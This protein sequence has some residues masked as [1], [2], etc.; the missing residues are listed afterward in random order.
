M[1]GAVSAVVATIRSSIMTIVLTVLGGILAS[2][3]RARSIRSYLRGLLL[4]LFLPR[5]CC[6]RRCA[7]RWFL[8][9]RCCCRC[10]CVVRRQWWGFVSGQRWRIGLLW[11]RGCCLLLLL[12]WLRCLCLGS[13]LLVILLVL[14]ISIG[15]V[16]MLLIVSTIII[17]RRIVAAAC[18]GVSCVRLCHDYEQGG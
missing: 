16:S 3:C 6:R 7:R 5:S 10:L 1:S 11:R 14:P 17:T 12:G 2:V 9:F 8:H 15:V 13:I 18:R 4:L